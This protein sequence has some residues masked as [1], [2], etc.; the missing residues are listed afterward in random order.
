MSDNAMTGFKD[1]VTQPAQQHH[2]IV[3]AEEWQAARK[4]FLAKEKEY[5]RLR[6]ELTRQRMELPWEKVEKNYVFDGPNG[7]ETLSDLFGG[8]SQLIIQH[9][10]YGPEEEQGCVGCSFAADHIEGTLP[11][12][13]H[14]DVSLVVVAR[15]PLAKLN[16][17]KKRM[18][19][20][21]KF[22]S[23]YGSDFNYDYHVSFSKEDLAK[24]ETFYNYGMINNNRMED[25]QGLSAFYKDEAGNIYHT[26]STYAR[27]GE[28]QLS[29]YNYLDIAPLGRNEHSERGD[30]TGWVRHHDKYEAKG[31]VDETGRYHEDKPDACCGS[32][33]VAS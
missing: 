30:L 16:A 18:N 25:L 11:H 28:L 10:M 1:E 8:R 15:A 26:Y 5:T 3:S 19:W 33:E 22:V 7:R 9:F 24:G 32:G 13:E 14:H 12:L 2:R 31:H 17:Y 21:F 29:T 6:D 23:S 4:Q 20:H 27:G